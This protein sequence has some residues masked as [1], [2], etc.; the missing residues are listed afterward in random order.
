VAP[1]LCN[2]ARFAAWPADVRNAVEAAM[3]AATALQRRLAAEEDAACLAQLLAEG[4]HV[5]R[6]DQFDRAAFVAVLADL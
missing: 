2:R 1:V 3:A 5:T 4:V 6:A